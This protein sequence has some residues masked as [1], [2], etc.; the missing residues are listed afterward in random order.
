MNDTDS[1]VRELA[2][3]GVLDLSAAREILRAIEGEPV[4]R[5]IRIDLSRTREFHDFAVA[6]LAEA[7]SSRRKRV[8]VAGLG[9]H[10][11]RMLGYLGL[12]GVVEEAGEPGD[13]PT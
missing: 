12:G 4:H 1:N 11:V 7:V 10:Q 3:E 9:V 2:V 5:E 8:V 6:V 13:S